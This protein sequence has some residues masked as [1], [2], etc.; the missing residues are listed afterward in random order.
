LCF[1]LLQKVMGIKGLLDLVA[2]VT[3]NVHISEYQGKVVAVGAFASVLFGWCA[4]D[5]RCFP[6]RRLLL[7][8]QEHLLVR[9]GPVHG[10]PDGQVEQPAFFFSFRA[11][12]HAT[13][14]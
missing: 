2:P 8:A 11:L 6:A 3:T 4:A 5:P 14:G 9:D 1:A 13:G 10:P 7:D 12:S